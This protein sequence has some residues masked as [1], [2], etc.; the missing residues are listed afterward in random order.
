VVGVSNVTGGVRF[1]RCAS[2]RKQDGDTK[3]IKV[4]FLAVLAKRCHLRT[5]LLVAAHLPAA[6]VRLRVA[7]RV[8]RQAA[9]AH[10]RAAVRVLRQAAPARLRVVVQVLR[11]AAPVLHR[12]RL[13]AQVAQAAAIMLAVSIQ[14]LFPPM[15]TG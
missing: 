14:T 1:T 3:I 2:P 6:P 12:V 10:L 15:M 13:Q 11:Q 4:A 5:V 7:V 9:P 8:L